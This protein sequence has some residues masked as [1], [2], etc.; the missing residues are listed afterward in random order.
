MA[1]RDEPN[2]GGRGRRDTTTDTRARGP[3]RRPRRGIVPPAPAGRPPAGR[4]AGADRHA[5]HHPALDGRAPRAGRCRP[6][7]RDAPGAQRRHAE[8]PRRAAGLRQP[9]ALLPDRRCPGG[10]WSASRSGC[11]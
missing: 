1:P 9:G 11:D 2:R 5:D 4:P 8:P 3:T 6:R 10:P 7:R